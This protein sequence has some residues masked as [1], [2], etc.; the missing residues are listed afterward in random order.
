MFELIL[1][2]N[3]MPMPIGSSA[4]WWMFAGMIARPRAISL[5]TSSGSIFSRRATYSISSVIT[6]LR[7]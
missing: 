5:R 6:P 2:L 1:H 3:A 7:A 4:L